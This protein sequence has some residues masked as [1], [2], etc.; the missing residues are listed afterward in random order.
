MGFSLL[1]GKCEVRGKVGRLRVVA[2]I[3]LNFRVGPMDDQGVV[4]S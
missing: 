1:E 4:L 3:E 2:R